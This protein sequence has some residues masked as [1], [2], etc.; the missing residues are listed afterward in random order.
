M[1]H[2]SATEFHFSYSDSLFHQINEVFYFYIHN[3]DIHLMNWCASIDKYNI[4]NHLLDDVPSSISIYCDGGG[5][6]TSYDP[7]QTLTIAQNILADTSRCGSSNCKSGLYS[8]WRIHPKICDV[9]CHSSITHKNYYL[10][11]MQKLIGFDF[12]YLES[13]KPDVAIELRKELVV[14]CPSSDDLFFGDVSQF[15][16]IKDALHIFDLI[17]PSSLSPEFEKHKK[18][19]LMNVI[20][21]KKQNPH[22]STVEVSETDILVEC[23]NIILKYMRDKET[24]NLKAFAKFLPSSTAYKSNATS[25]RTDNLCIFM[26]IIKQIRVYIDEV[27]LDKV[28]TRRRILNTGTEYRELLRQQQLSRILTV[29]FE[30]GATS[31][32]IAND[33]K[34]HL[35][36]K[37]SELRSY[38][39]GVETFSQQIAD[40]DIE[41]VKGRVETYQTDLDNVVENLKHRMTSLFMK[42]FATVGLDILEKMVVLAMDIVAAYNPLKQMFTGNN[43]QDVIES[44][45]A[46]ANAIADIAKLANVKSAYEELTTK[47]TYLSKRLNENDD[48]LGNVYD[49]I[50]DD[51]KIIDRIESQ[52]SKNSFIKEYK[53]Y[54]PKVKRYEI[55]QVSSLWQNLIATICDIISGIDTTLG[56]IGKIFALGDCE[57]LPSLVDEMNVI[58]EEIYDYQFELMDSMAAYIRASVALDAAKEISSEF[59]EVTELNINSESTL[60]TLQMIGGLSSIT[61][62]THILQIVNLYCNVLEY[63]EGGKKPTECK[64]IETDVDLLIANIEPTCISQTYK[65]YFAPTQQTNKNDQAYVN[66]TKLFSGS[67]VPFKIPNAQWLVDHNWIHPNEKD[68][69]LYVKKFDVFLPV[70]PKYPTEFYVT[71]DPVLHNV[72]VPGPSATEYIIIPHSHFIHEYSMGPHRLRCSEPK[73]Q[74]PYTTCEQEDISLLCHHSDT[75]N[76]H[77]YPSIYSQW[78]LSV[79]GGKDFAIP[80]PATNMSVIFGIQICKIA[81]YD[82]NRENIAHSQSIAADC[83][84]EGH[85]RPNDKSPCA[86]CPTGSSSSLGG[87]YCEMN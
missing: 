28:M 10:E 21:L 61:Y 30:Q 39:E 22:Y 54:D 14:A 15:C 78:S 76:W 58:Y 5:T 3:V 45:A 87:Y 1:M 24:S 57:S 52:K 43:A 37:F 2:I 42:A 27:K 20:I 82:Y 72:V 49:F 29:L 79:S 50:Q 59:E 25:C 85:Y 55:T 66:I 74:N 44:A 36:T 47:I 51:K 73:V 40:A 13:L 38:F 70:K 84:E 35:T 67:T 18:A 34:R 56:A 64:G 17:W 53:A 81:Q 62:Q 12:I 6:T 83:C 31:L 68:F 60:T 9:C 69:A 63:M 26:K 8:F 65:Y 32:Q 23:T 19:I 41:Y 80:K 71:A 4:D 7:V 16:Q 75:V 46:L 77:L 48:V 11:M 86:P 33:L